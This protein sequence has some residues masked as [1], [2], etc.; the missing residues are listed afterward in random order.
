MKENEAL[1]ETTKTLSD[2]FDKFIDLLQKLCD[3]VEKL[4]NKVVRSEREV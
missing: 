3:E 4:K 1:A 2:N